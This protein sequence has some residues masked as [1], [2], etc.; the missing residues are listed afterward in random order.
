MEYK[1]MLGEINIQKLH[2]R[3]ESSGGTEHALQ[4]AERAI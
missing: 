4:E 2:N 3:S 1:S